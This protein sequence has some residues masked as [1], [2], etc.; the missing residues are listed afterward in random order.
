[1]NLSYHKAVQ[2]E[3]E[4]ACEWYDERKDRL[5]DEFFQEVERVL[6]LIATN[7]EAL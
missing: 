3:V 5:G 1:M 6:G 7:P 4:Q 2:Q